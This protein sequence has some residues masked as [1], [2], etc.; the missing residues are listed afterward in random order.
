MIR[1]IFV[2]VAG[3][4]ALALAPQ[5]L[6]AQTEVEAAEMEQAMALLGGMFPVE[7]LTA[8]QQARLPQAQRIIDRMIPEGTLGEMMGSTYDALL[9][10]LT[11]AFDAPAL[12][13]VA[14]GTGFDASDLALEAAQAEELAQLF[15]PAYAERQKR[16][17]ALFPAMMTDLM[18][19]MEPTMRKAMSE[20][21]AI[22]F[23]QTELND[24]EAFFQTASG[25][26]FAR[27]S[28]TMSSDPRI[29]GATMETMPQLMETFAGMDRKFAEAS[30]DLPA[31]RRFADLS[32]A[33]QVRV[34]DA[35]GY[36]IEE[37][38][39][40]DETGGEE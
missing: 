19:V 11:A 12:E 16:E 28:F 9:G 2:G 37:I 32:P 6:A 26:S 23:T 22:N 17:K 38:L 4:A 34:A 21:Y 20:L 8:E 27:K 10:P 31:R 13:A 40:L 5:P 18:N 14:N 29:V 24:I 35:L 25:T 1:R 39:A 33:E 30:A 3:A 36:S 7:P 15:D